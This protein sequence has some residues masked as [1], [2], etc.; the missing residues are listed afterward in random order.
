MEFWVS[1]II[2]IL[3]AVVVL[4]MMQ[5][6]NIRIM[7]IL[8]IVCN[9]MGGLSY[10]FLDG[11][12]GSAVYFVAMLQA[13]VYC[14]FRFKNIEPPKWLTYVCCVA[15]VA[16]SL[17]T[18]QKPQDIIAAVAALTCALALVQAKPSM[19]RVLMFANGILWMFYDVSVGAY[20]MILSHALT[21][22]SALICMIRLD[23]KKKKDAKNNKV[24]KKRRKKHWKKKNKNKANK[25]NKNV[26]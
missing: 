13:G 20:G 7:L 2:G 10:I 18:Y 26:K 21:S 17:T 16:C 24:T 14:I 11:F 25:E 19:Y 8:D 5:M 23:F 15:F 3:T 6:K 12:S 1:Q 9:L 4:I 22:G